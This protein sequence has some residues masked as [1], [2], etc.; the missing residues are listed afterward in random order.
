[1]NCLEN[2]GLQFM[3]GKF[4]SWKVIAPRWN[5]SP[6]KIWYTD[7]VSVNY[8]VFS[9]FLEY[10]LYCIKETFFNPSKVGRKLVKLN[11]FNN[12]DYNNDNYYDH[13]NYHNYPWARM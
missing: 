3:F 1:M 5:V 2:E 6:F 9:F 7:S 10:N 11:D 13:N 8:I 4:G 12:N